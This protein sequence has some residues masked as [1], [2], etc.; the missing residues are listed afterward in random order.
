[1]GV[2]CSCDGDSELARARAL[3]A[4][5]RSTPMIPRVHVRSV[6]SAG[7]TGKSLGLDAAKD[8]HEWPNLPDRKLFFLDSVYAC[9]RVGP[10]R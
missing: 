6:W 5:R 9:R 8:I 3:D 2:G 7:L 4:E 1:M 10:P